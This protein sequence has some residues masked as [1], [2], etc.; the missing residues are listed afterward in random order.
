[1]YI[2][3]IDSNIRVTNV[4]IFHDPEYGE[5]IDITVKEV[6]LNDGK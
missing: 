4:E 5:V 3:L 2:F 1:M 6:N